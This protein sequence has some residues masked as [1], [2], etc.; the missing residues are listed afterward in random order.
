MAPGGGRGPARSRPLSGE[1]KGIKIFSV[2]VLGFLLLAISLAAAAP[3]AAAQNRLDFRPTDLAIVS[4]DRKQVIGHGRYTTE[5]AGGVEIVK[6]ENRYLNGEYDLEVDRL[7]PRPGGQPPLLLAFRHSFY[8]ADGSLQLE[9]EMDR[10]SGAG[11][12][13]KPGGSNSETRSTT[14]ELPDDTYAGASLL[15]PLEA[16]LR[17]GLDRIKLHAFNCVPG[18][19]VI[20]VQA[21]LPSERSQWP[22]YSG[23][24]ARVEVRPDF[25]W[26]NFLAAPFVPKI[27]AWFDPGED[28]TYVGGRLQRFYGGPTIV[29]VKLS[30]QHQLDLAPAPPEPED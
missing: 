24:L 14:L 29:L 22:L 26:L 28:W 25:G 17:E 19:R 4:A 21:R 10:A 12:C 1:T 5:Q 6:G 18:P 30:P 13:S 27:N 16:G 15:I 23:E 2:R 9:A 7:Q 11:S 8:R 20:E 3:P